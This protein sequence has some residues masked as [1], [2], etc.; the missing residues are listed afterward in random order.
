MTT[1]LDV[2]AALVVGGMVGTIGQAT[3]SIA[4]L[5]KLQDQAQQ[6]GVSVSDIFSALRFFI[7]LMIGFI[8]GMIA[9]ISMGLDKFSQLGTSDTALLMGIAAAGY[10]GTDFIEAFATRVE[11]SATKAPAD[12]G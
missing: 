9:V 10:A 4:G 5:K 6:D 8:A 3:R 7:S 1:T 2:S 11:P 12:V